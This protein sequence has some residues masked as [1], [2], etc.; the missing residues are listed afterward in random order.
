MA[1]AFGEDDIFAVF[2]DDSG[3]K[4]DKNNTKGKKEAT[5]LS[6]STGASSIGEKREFTPGAIDLDDAGAK[7]ARVDDMER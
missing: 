7:K 5:D 3:K 2:E 4:S 1:D 6:T